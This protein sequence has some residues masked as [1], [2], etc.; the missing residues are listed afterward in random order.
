MILSLESGKK[1][2]GLRPA[3]ETRLP[4]TATSTPATGLTDLQ[5]PAQHRG[6]PQP[7]KFTTALS[8]IA[9]ES[10][11]SVADLT[12]DTNFA[13]IG[14]DSLLGLTISARF[15][16]EIDMDLD[17]NAMFYEYP[18]VQDIKALFSAPEDTG[19]TS[20]SDSGAGSGLDTPSTETEMTAVAPSDRSNLLEGDFVRA[21]E[22][23]SEES[24]VALADL[25]EDTNFADCGVDS[26]LSL[27]IA[28][29][30]QDTFGLDIQHEA[31]MFE[32]ETV[33]KLKDMLRRELSAANPGVQPP[34]VSKPVVFSLIPDT[35]QPCPS[36]ENASHSIRGDDDHDEAVTLS[37]R[38]GAVEELV[39]KYTAG[40]S[41]PVSSLS[42]SPAA[43]AADEKVIL[44]TG[45]TGSLGAHLAYHLVQLEDVKMVVCLNR[46]NKDEAY[47]RQRKSMREKGIRFPAHL[48][49]KLKVFQA[50]SSKPRLGLDKTEYDSLVN[51]VTHLI[52]NAWPMNAKRALWEFESQFQVFRNLIDFA[53]DVASCR[54][55]NFQFSFQMVSSI[56]VVGHYGRD[57]GRETER[58]VVPE[59]RTTIASVLANGYAEAKW[60]CERMLEETLQRHPDRFRAMVVRLGQ[61]A[62]SKTSGY[63][64]PMEHFGFLV[65]SSQTLKAL[66]DVDG[67]L[68]WTP[69]ND[70]AATLADLVLSDRTPHLFYHID[71]PVGQPWREMNAILAD[72]LHIPD[73]IPFEAWLERVR[74]APQRDNPAS[75]LSDFLDENYL[76][77]SCGR[78][79]LDVKKTLEHSKTLAAIG[80]VAEVVVRRYI[81]IW[82]EIGFL[83]ST[84]EDRINLESDRAQLWGC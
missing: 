74:T 7:S 79:V 38:G 36:E 49:P 80:P 2:Q 54:P 24:G 48:E 26:L 35:I 77:M 46:E 55:Q 64:N 66:P 78:L 29:R 17:F 22:I 41:V 27:V 11:L 70:V 53:C 83:K 60:G 62:G 84:E 51:S 1:A 69:V 3:Q 73:L 19:T 39:H 76:R 23:I 61:I 58:T 9:E 47:A 57:S 65:K 37:A 40:F 18:T 42:P 33:G 68:Y 32:C 44:V 50:D 21:L 43:P 20:P 52:H 6:Q 75:L 10:G 25:E 15:K 8:I 67:M 16:E 34:A 30:F 13:D 59:D 82:R 14:I 72:T 31:L 28:S 5:Q 81:H 4:V 45:T 63:W 71:N 12:Y 56:G